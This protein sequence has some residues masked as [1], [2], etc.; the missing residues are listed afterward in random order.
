MLFTI[1]GLHRIFEPAIM[2]K[3]QRKMQALRREERSGYFIALCDEAMR[4][5]FSTS[6]LAFVR[7][8]FL[9]LIS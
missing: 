3:Y 4:L 6:I 9:E 5:F 8:T 1:F 2:E 7:V